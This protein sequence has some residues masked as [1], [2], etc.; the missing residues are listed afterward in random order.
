[1]IEVTYSSNN[2]SIKGH[3]NFEDIG[4]DIVCSGVSTLVV[5]C[6]NALEGFSKKEIKQIDGEV[7]ITINHKISKEDQ[8]RIDMMKLGIKLIAKEYPKF[9]KIK[10]E[11]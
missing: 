7:S 3:S 5:T 2:I 11:K 8:V 4:K 9:V 1:M 6:V 10:K